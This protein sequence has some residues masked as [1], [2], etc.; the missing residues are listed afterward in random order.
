M[1]RMA[2]TAALGLI[3]NACPFG[4]GEEPDGYARVTGQVLL[5]DGSPY[6]GRIHILCWEPPH[7]SL[8]FFRDGD[9][10]ERGQYFVLV[11][12]PAYSQPPQGEPFEFLCRAQSGPRGAPFAARY[13]TVPFGRTRVEA[14][15]TRIDLREGEMEPPPH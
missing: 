1:I 14:P 9:L 4:A 3:L 7:E 6:P 5:R 10:D 15:T 11:E 8:S 2:G 12:A 13:M